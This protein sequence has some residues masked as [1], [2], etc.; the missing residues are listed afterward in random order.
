MRAAAPAPRPLLGVGLIFAMAA[1]FAVLDTSAKRLGIA[2]PV[3]VV[4]WSRYAFQALAMT[5]WLLRPGQRHLLRAA[6]PRFQLVRGAG[7]AS[8]ACSTCRWP[9]SPR[10]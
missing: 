2:L 6:H 3:L 5:V 10:W 8:S 4:L 1:C 9:S 7:S